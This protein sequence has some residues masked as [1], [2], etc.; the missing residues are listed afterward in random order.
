[1]YLSR[2]HTAAYVAFL[3]SFSSPGYCSP[4]MQYSEGERKNSAGARFTAGEI[5]SRRPGTDTHPWFSRLVLYH[6]HP[7]DTIPPPEHH[8]R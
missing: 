1:M 3:L 6:P 4:S 2:Q 5:V 8:T 7:E